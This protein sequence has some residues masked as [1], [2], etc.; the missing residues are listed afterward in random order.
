MKRT[1]F[2]AMITSSLLFSGCIDNTLKPMTKTKAERTDNDLGLP[3]YSGIKPTLAVIKFENQGGWHGRYDLG[4]NLTSML[5]SAMDGTKRFVM[6]DR[7]NM[8]AIDAEQ[9]LRDSGRAVQ[10]GQAAQLGKI[11]LARFMA[12][13]AII[14]ASEDTQGTGG[15]VSLP[16]IGGFSP[17]IGGSKTKSRIVAEIKITDTST[18][19]IVAREKVTGE[20]GK[21]KLSVGVFGR[22]FGGNLDSFA[23]TPMGEAAQD[24]IAQAARFIALEIEDHLQNSGAT[25]ASPKIALVNGDDIIINRGSEHGVAVGAIYKVMTAG[26]PVYDPDTGVQISISRGKEIAK[27]K[28]T[29][30]EGKVSYCTLESGDK[31]TVGQSV[32]A[33]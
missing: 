21:V 15:G 18:S 14:E 20:S 19:E 12:S 4:R 8:S 30:V 9:R 10:A 3:P 2:F 17:R 23:R 7:E 5:G 13:G 27:M 1:A 11:K 26:Q 22:G 16:S 24:V 32:A 28:V 6:V 29:R 33:E 31:P 25:A